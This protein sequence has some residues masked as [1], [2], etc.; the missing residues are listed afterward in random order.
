[1]TLLVALA[2]YDALMLAIPIIA[3]VVVTAA[4]GL[5]VILRV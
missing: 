1:M 3:A 4:V 2:I 5:L